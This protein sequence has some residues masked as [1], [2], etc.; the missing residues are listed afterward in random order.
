MDLRA[1]LTTAALP[2]GTPAAVA[3]VDR[4]GHL[5]MAV[6]GMWAD[7]RP[8]TADD[9]FYG[10]SLA[11]Q[12]TGATIAALV[13]QAGLD[14]DFA[15]GQ[16]IELPAW[17]ADVTI[18]H[19]LHHLGGLP[20]ADPTVGPGHWDMASA[21]AIL[22]QCQTLPATAGTRFDYSNLGYIVLARIIERI[23]GVSFAEFTQ[24]QLLEPLAL[25]GIGF[26]SRPDFSQ[27]PLM[28]P[29]EPR[30]VGDGGLWT[31]APA[32]AQ[33]LD[34]QNRDTLGSADLVQQPYGAATDYGWGLG[35]RSFRGHPLLIH[36][37]GWPGAYSKAVRCPALGLSVV[38]LAADTSD[39]RVLALVDAVLTEIAA[40]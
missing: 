12:I 14:P 10:A 39:A 25:S 26:S 35:L 13:R 15:V 40:P 28:G 24:I 37:G 36:G 21:M 7:G 16:I 1:A 20:G 4:A 9:R 38:A 19:L 3:V 33:W 17:G 34:H 27:L 29:V 6:T 31:T 32:F 11:K 5:D 30:T 22:Q 23:T 18:R 2:A 8:V